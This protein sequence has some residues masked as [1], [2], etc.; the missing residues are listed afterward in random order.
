MFKSQVRPYMFKVII[1]FFLQK[2]DLF[3]ETNISHCLKVKAWLDRF[4]V[5]PD[6]LFW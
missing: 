4:P 5:E 3:I 2:S 1:N 6:G